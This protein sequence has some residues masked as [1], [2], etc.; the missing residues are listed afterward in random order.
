MIHSSFER[1]SIDAIV[2]R[3]QGKGY[4]ELKKEVGDIVFDF[5]SDLQKRYKEIVASGVI[6]EVLREGNAKASRIAEKKVRKVKK[7]LGFLILK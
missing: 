4:G 2:E 7:K 3:Y 6:E 5:L 1:E